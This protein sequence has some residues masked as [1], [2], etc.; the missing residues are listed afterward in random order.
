MALGQLFRRLFQ[1]D[2]QLARLDHLAAGHKEAS[3]HIDF[4]RRV[5]GGEF[6]EIPFTRLQKLWL[7][8]LPPGCGPFPKVHIVA[9]KVRR[10]P[11]FGWLKEFGAAA[12]ALGYG[13]KLAMKLALR[14]PE[15]GYSEMLLADARRVLKRTRS[16]HGTIDLT[17]ASFR[18]GG[19][20]LPLVVGMVD[21]TTMDAWGDLW[22]GPD[23]LLLF[24]G[25]GESQKIADLTQL[26][27]LETQEEAVSQHDRELYRM[28]LILH[29]KQAPAVQMQ[30]SYATTSEEAD[31]LEIERAQSE[32]LKV[33]TAVEGLNTLVESLR[34]GGQIGKPGH[35]PTTS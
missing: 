14:S 3:A 31:D 25:M 26:D 7:L 28:R 9:L 1:S 22:L 32:R 17:A 27:F 20:L 24:N 34:P 13:Q 16:I 11:I 35:K 23:G 5:I 33:K 6:P 19:C 2:S 29:L 8:T 30:C 10:G 15:S 18:D 21:S 12:Q 4:H